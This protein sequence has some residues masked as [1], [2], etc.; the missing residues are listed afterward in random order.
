MNSAIFY[1]LS[2]HTYSDSS[3]NFTTDCKTYSP[4]KHF[5]VTVFCD[6]C[7]TQSLLCSKSKKFNTL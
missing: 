6:H 7:S 3:M 2:D 5:D 1:L 4:S